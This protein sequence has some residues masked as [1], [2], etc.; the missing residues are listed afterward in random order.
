MS[1][2]DDVFYMRLALREAYK[3][4]GKTSPNPPVGAIV[5]DPTSGEVISRGY[6]R[7]YG[8]PHAEVVALH[9]AGDRARGAILYVTLEPCCHYGKT[10]PCTEAII[11][12]GIKRV[13]CGIRDPNPI[14]CNG[15]IQ[16]RQRG[17]EVKVGVLAEEIKYLKRFFLSRILRKRPWVM[18]KVAQSMDGRIAVSTGD[19][20]WISGYRARVFA[21]KLRSI[22]DAILVGKETV[23]KDDPE[24]TT[25]LV[26]G[27]NPIR[28]VLD[29]NAT[30]SPKFKVFQV[31]D[32][33]KTILVC[34]EKVSKDKLADFERQ[35]VQV[36]Q[37]PVEDRGIDLN[38]F[39]ERAN[40]EG[41]TS[42]LVEGGGVLHGAFLRKGLI[43]ELFIVIAP[44]IIGDPKGVF[45]F[46]AEPLERLKDAHRLYDL[47]LK[48]LDE[49][50][51]FHGFTEGGINLLNTHLEYL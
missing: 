48:K 18:V 51:L 47:K 42:I 24:L 12:A 37:L 28:I 45:S 21:H 5:V 3:G 29:T 26:R 11:N 36:W 23:L 49:C 4:Y 9:K 39:L 44:I 22:A 41:I 19:S 50:Y 8:E 30:L 27:K 33:K 43:D 13:V 2:R 40:L 16:L 31:S 32:T 20:K 17:V 6:H 7:A 15:L 10:P 38:C 46:M 1:Q 25:R 14:A 35:G 34:S